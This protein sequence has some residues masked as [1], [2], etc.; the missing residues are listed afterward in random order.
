MPKTK[1]NARAAAGKPDDDGARPRAME[2][3][4]GEGVL[5]GREAGNVA[6][7]A[8][9]NARLKV[10][11][12]HLAVYEKMLELLTFVKTNVEAAGDCSLLAFAAGFEITERHELLDVTPAGRAILNKF[13]LDAVHGLTT[14]KKA[15]TGGEEVSIYDSISA[16]FTELKLPK[17]RRSERVADAV[18]LTR[19]KPWKKTKYYGHDNYA[20][21]ATL[22]LIQNRVSARVSRP[23]PHNTALL[24]S[25]SR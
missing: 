19:F 23:S 4:I 16:I 14:G 8:Q 21:W 6:P 3:G 11:A 20:I 22:G 10:W 17:I 15:S 9:K 13:R 12:Y 24:S 7:P 2:R 5:A 1:G 25:L 18:L